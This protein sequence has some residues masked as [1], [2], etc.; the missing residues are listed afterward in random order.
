MSSSPSAGRIPKIDSHSTAPTPVADCAPVGG[1]SGDSPGCEATDAVVVAEAA[2]LLEEEVDHLEERATGDHWDV[3]TES[4]MVHA[5]PVLLG[6]VAGDLWIP[7]L[8][9]GDQ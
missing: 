8:D 1:S 9:R 2:E 4:S 6:V 5:A 3:E 7:L